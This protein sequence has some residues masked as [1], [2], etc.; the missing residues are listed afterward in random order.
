MGFGDIAEST[1]NSK[2]SLAS[3]IRGQLLKSNKENESLKYAKKILICGENGSG[4]STL[5]LDLLCTDLKEDEMII[6]VDVDN[7]GAEVIV[8]FFEELWYNDNIKHYSPYTTKVVVRDGKEVDIRDEEGII[9]K[10]IAVT[11]AIK[12]LIDD[13]FKIKGVIVD[14]VSFLLEY[15]EAKMRLE[16]NIAPDGG[17]NM[18]V[19][20]V[21]NQF[22]REFY[23][24][25]MGLPIP[26]IFVA[27]D[28]FI[29]KP[30]D[31]NDLS[32][33][34]QRFIDECSI[35]IETARDTHD[36]ITEYYATIKKD[37]SMPIN[38]EKTFTFLSI[39]I[40]DE[41]SEKEDL[42]ASDFGEDT[43]EGI[44]KA[45]FRVVR[46]IFNKPQ[47]KTKSEKK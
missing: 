3:E 38:L 21:R 2:E 27:H 34:K 4:K 46:K 12:S 28:D 17:V 7:S 13:G 42:Q 20:K 25:Y 43:S 5:A 37:R 35:R 15:A 14:G 26:V 16:R 47:D 19:W 40:S 32:G 18:L 24:P 33:V 39:D 44:A 10:T 22:F 6:Y 8:N 31:D 9:N 1:R 45:I 23:S 30:D 11:S 36:N 41:I 29:K